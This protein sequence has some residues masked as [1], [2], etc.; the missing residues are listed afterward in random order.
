MQQAAC[1]SWARAPAGCASSSSG[2]AAA[3]RHAAAAGGRPQRRQL[4]VAAAAEA[5][6]MLEQ[7][8]D[9]SGVQ[10]A[11]FDARAFRRSLNSTGRYTRKPSNDPDSL[12]VRRRWA[13][14][15]AWA[16]HV[17]DWEA[18]MCAAEC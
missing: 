16:P 18:A 15:G 2:A 5:K 10:P 12:Q 13:P 6:E 1:T 9:R 11:D 17:T 14:L 8:A 4:R 7:A 3:R